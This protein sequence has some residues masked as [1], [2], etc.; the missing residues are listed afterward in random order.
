MV[1]SLY[2]AVPKWSKGRVCKT[3]IHGSESHLHLSI[4][5]HS[6]KYNLNEN[7]YEKLT[8]LGG[9]R[10]KSKLITFPDIHNRFLPDFIRGYFDGDGSVFFV[11]YTR[12]K[13]KKLASEL[14]TNFTSGS[15]KFLKNLKK[16]M[17][18]LNEEI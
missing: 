6:R 13:D 14:R 11:K 8:E 4:L 18:I 15:K 12:T 10:R 7:F 17:R 5:Y 1:L 16:L 3:L 9:F 2:G